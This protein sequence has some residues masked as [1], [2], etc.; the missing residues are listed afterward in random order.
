MKV[1]DK[2]ELVGGFNQTLRPTALAH[3]PAVAVGTQNPFEYPP[4]C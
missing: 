2:R 3:V 1:A 4:C